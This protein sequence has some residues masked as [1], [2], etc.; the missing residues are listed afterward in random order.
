[1]LRNKTI[2]ASP[3]AYL[4]AR[5]RPATNHLDMGITLELVIG[6]VAICLDCTT[7]TTEKFAGRLVGA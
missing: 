6:T 2:R 3:E 5:M 1:M 7:V 4:P